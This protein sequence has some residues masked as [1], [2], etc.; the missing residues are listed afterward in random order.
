MEE[1]SLDDF[2]SDN[3]GVEGIEETVHYL[4]AQAQLS[5]LG[6]CFAHGQSH[7]K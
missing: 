4:I 7:D 2:R 3:G 5:V 1:L 6:K